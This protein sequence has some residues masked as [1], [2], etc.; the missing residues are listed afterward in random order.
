MALGPRQSV[1]G[2]SSLKL[3]AAT[4]GLRTGNSKGRELPSTAAR[5]DLRP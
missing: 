4:I 1:C 3:D 5:D 2:R